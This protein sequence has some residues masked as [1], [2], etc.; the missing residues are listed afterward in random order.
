MEEYDD[1]D[2]GA[3]IIVS[4]IGTTI[5]FSLVTGICLLHQAATHKQPREVLMEDNE[6]FRGARDEGGNSKIEVPWTEINFPGKHNMCAR[7]EFYEITNN[8][9]QVR[10]MT[11]SP[12][13]TKVPKICRSAAPQ[14]MTTISGMIV[15]TQ[16]VTTLTNLMT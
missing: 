5:S 9:Q 8:N 13:T 6:C 10:R 2:Y 4:A 11:L 14:G 15:L 1:C 3:A 7:V 12:Q 16:K